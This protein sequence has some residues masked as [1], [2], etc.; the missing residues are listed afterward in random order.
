MSSFLFS[1]RLQPWSKG[2]L[3]V[4]P[5]LSVEV[6]GSGA[7]ELTCRLDSSS[8]PFSFRYYVPPRLRS[9]IERTSEVQGAETI[10]L[11]VNPGGCGVGL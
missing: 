11:H 9:A 8:F 6:W 5:A 3:K 4:L 7:S 10:Y 1:S 2:E